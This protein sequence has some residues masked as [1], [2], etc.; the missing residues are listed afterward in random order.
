MPLSQ[1]KVV[2][3]QPVDWADMDSFRHVN[4]VVYFRYFENARLE[5][6]RRLVWLAFEAA[7]GIGPILAS[8]SARFRKPLTWPDIIDIG[9]RVAAV[10]DDRFTFEHRIVSRK[11]QAVAAEGEGVVVTF[12]YRRGVKVPMPDELRR[13]IAALEATAGARPSSA[14]EALRR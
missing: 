2:I 11:L 3:D 4:N 9:V 12:D 13:R 14:E 5:Y 6:I 10:G 7:T 8:T 1:F